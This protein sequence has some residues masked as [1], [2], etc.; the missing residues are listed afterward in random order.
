MRA[1][2][3]EPAGDGDQARSKS[4]SDRSAQADRAQQPSSSV[5]FSFV[6]FFPT[7]PLPGRFE[8]VTLLN[9]MNDGLHE[10][11]QPG[12]KPFNGYKPALGC[13][14]MHI[15]CDPQDYLTFCG[16]RIGGARAR[17]ARSLARRAAAARRPAGVTLLWPC[18]CRSHS[19][20][21]RIGN[22]LASLG[23][24]H[25]YV[26]A[27]AMREVDWQLRSGLDSGRLAGCVLAR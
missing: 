13:P 16:T 6:L 2:D 15:S 27:N 9:S 23:P 26:V 19:L 5:A 10:G 22:C 14:S 8:F 17:R 4:W 24:L 1:I 7:S 3:C 11:N 25:M 20:Y 21:V 18:Q 12:T